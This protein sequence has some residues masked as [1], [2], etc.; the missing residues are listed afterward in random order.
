MVTAACMY[1]YSRPSLKKMTAAPKVIVGDRLDFTLQFKNETP[2]D[3][4]AVEIVDSMPP[5]VEPLV[6]R[7]RLSPSVR[8]STDW[9]EGVLV[10]LIPNGVSRG[11]TLRIHIPTIVREDIDTNRID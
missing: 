4:A 1:S 11:K 9:R 8:F 2:L 3:L 7:I 5:E 10:I 6:D